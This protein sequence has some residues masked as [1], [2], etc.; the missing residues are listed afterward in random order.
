MAALRDNNMSTVCQSM[1]N[2][3]EAEAEAEAE[4]RFH[5]GKFGGVEPDVF[6]PG[7]WKPLDIRKARIAVSCGDGTAAL[8]ET[9]KRR[10]A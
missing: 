1:L 5:L 9:E 7:V 8:D 4:A 10:P 3:P 6:W 2:P